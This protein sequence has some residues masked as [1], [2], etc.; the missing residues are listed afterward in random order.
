[1]LG[2]GRVLVL[3]QHPPEARACLCA[4]STVCMAAAR[5]DTSVHGSS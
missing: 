1:M 4:H 2:I 5:E 3:T